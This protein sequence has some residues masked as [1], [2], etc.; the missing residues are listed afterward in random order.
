MTRASSHYWM[1]AEACELLDRAER[2][3]RQFFR[4]LPPLAG[5]TLWEPPVDVFETERALWIVVALPGVAAEDLELVNDAGTLLVAGT[6]TL[7][8][9]LIGTEIRRLEIPA[10][11]F[12]RRIPLPQGRFD[13]VERRLENGCLILGLRKL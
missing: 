8:A 5:R 12:E 6:R 4:P 9:E 1:W 3:Q 2:L 10:G 11:R 13:L 7:P